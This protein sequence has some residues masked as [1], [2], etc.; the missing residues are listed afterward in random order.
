[1]L[2]AKYAAMKRFEYRVGENVLIFRFG[3]TSNKK[4]APNNKISIGQVYTF[5]IAQFEHIQKGGDIMGIFD[6]DE[7]CCLDCPLRKSNN[8]GKLTCYTNKWPQARGFAAM[9][10][11]VIRKYKGCENIPHIP[12]DLPAEILEECRGKYIRW[13]TYGEPVFTPF[14]WMQAIN[15]VAFSYTGY[16][17]QYAKE[18]YY[19][20]SLYLMASTH[21]IFERAMANKLGWLCFTSTSDSIG[22]LVCPASNE[23]GFKTTCFKC[24]LCSGIMGK[25]DKNIQILLH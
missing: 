18:E 23:S 8:N 2:T 1:M 4:I 15:N 5:S 20:Y 17:H 19:P 10:R 7:S 3:I 14:H 12:Q 11:S 25:G 21:S 6:H 16:T 24:G 9:I 13:G 22:D